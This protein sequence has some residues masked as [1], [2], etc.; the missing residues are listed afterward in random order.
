[1]PRSAVS[2]IPCCLHAAR[3]DC[4]SYKA[5]V[6]L[7]I[8][9][10]VPLSCVQ[11]LSY[12]VYR[13]EAS[14]VWAR[15]VPQA[16]PARMAWPEPRVLFT[17]SNE[18]GCGVKERLHLDVRRSRSTHKRTALNEA[19]NLHQNLDQDKLPIMLL[20]ADQARCGEPAR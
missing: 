2:R 9:V 12:N 17:A 10:Q 15:Y 20:L 16:N 7:L 3:R 13:D 14:S 11:V 5:H 1:M 8:T 18:T 4:D 19:F 6:L